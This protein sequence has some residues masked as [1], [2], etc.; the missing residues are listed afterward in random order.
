[1]D[2]IE[3]IVADKTGL[4][5]PVGNLLR[6]NIS[7]DVAAVDKEFPLYGDFLYADRLSTGTISVRINS[8]GMPDFPF[9]RNTLV[10]NFPIG[11]CYLSWPAQ[12]GLVFNLWFGTGADIFPPTQDIATI[13]GVVA[14]TPFTTFPVDDLGIT[15]GVAFS[16]GT[17]QVAN[18]PQNIIS[19]G[20]NVNGYVLWE[21]KLQSVNATVVP[22]AALLAK[23]TAPATVADGDVLVQSGYS[24]LAAS[25]NVLVGGGN[26]QKPI[27][28]AAGKRLDYICT[29]TETGSSQ[30]SVLYTLK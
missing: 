8:P 27:N 26:L 3:K 12:P 13:S 7:L 24:A 9:V 14:V 22:L 20:A 10:H 15:Y 1:M 6:L 4:S 28:V 25:P 11:K 30:R 19:A 29:P 16:S 5:Y 18:T 17:L 23:T 21:G 2:A